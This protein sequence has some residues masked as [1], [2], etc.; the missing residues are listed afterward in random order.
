MKF[1]VVDQLHKRTYIIASGK[2]AHC[3]LNEP[4]IIPHITRSIQKSYNVK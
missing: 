4:T 1:I 2:S 3:R